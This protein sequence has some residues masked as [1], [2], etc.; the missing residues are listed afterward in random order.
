MTS[1][2]DSWNLESRPFTKHRNRRSRLRRFAVFLGKNGSRNEFCSSHPRLWV[3]LVR[4]RQ[5]RLWDKFNAA[6]LKL[7]RRLLRTLLVEI[8]SIESKSKPSA[9]AYPNGLPHGRRWKWMWSRTFVGLQPWIVI[10]KVDLKRT[11]SKYQKVFTPIINYAADLGV[12]PWSTKYC[13]HGRLE[14]FG[15]F[16]DLQ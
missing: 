5:K 11:Y 9:P 13:P 16:R 8:Q 7:H 2:F 1:A 10:K 3:L 14:S 15:S 12:Q 6:N 4:R